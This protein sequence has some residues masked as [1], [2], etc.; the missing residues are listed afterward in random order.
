MGDETRV[1][2]Q[3]RDEIR[4]TNERLD[5]TNERLEAVERRQVASET[6]LATELVAVA[7]AVGSVRELLASRLDDRDRL[8]DHEQR[9]RALERGSSGH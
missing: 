6:R 4:A 7:T 3:I 2:A 1:T 9:I 8:D 5:A